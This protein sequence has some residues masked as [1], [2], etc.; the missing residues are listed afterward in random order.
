MWFIS[1]YD[2]SNG[3]ME[4]MYHRHRRG[5]LLHANSKFSENNHTPVRQLWGFYNPTLTVPSY[6]AWR[7]TLEGVQKNHKGFK[8]QRDSLNYAYDRFE[9]LVSCDLEKEPCTGLVHYGLV[10]TNGGVYQCWVK[11]FDGVKIS[12]AGSPTFPASER[13]M[14][15]GK[16]IHETAMEKWKGLYVRH[17]FPL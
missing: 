5:A 12:P 8:D 17:L 15:H 13:A 2:T 10:K 4:K 16:K 9:E 3:V 1:W 11:G 14:A 6:R 7:F